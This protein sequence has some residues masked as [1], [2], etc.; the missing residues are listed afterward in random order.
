MGTW[1]LI[2]GLLIAGMLL[3]ALAAADAK[4]HIMYVAAESVSDPGLLEQIASFVGAEERSF[5]LA[6]GEPEP[7]LQADA[8][9]QPLNG[10][11][12]NDLSL[13]ASIR[14][15]DVLILRGGSFMEWYDRISPPGPR[16]FLAAE[17]ADFYR[18][19]KGIVAYGGACMFLSGGALVDRRLKKNPERNP[20]DTHPWIPRIAVGIA[21]PCLFDSSQW[22][23][24]SPL[25]LLQAMV[26]T[27]V[28]RGVFFEGQVALDHDR[29][30]QHE[31]VRGPGSV[32]LFDLRRARTGPTGIR[33]GRLSRLTAGDHWVDG[34]KLPRA[35]TDKRLTAKPTK[36]EASAGHPWGKETG[37]SASQLIDWLPAAH[38]KPATR[39]ATASHWTLAWDESSRRDSGSDEPRTWIH[40]PFD[41][42]WPK[43]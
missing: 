19:R 38:S 15:A 20:Q 39:K 8:Y 24:G 11:A 22:E 23:A 36:E 17:L 42:A 18:A 29:V 3:P 6:F 2:P 43:R 27:Q 16:T 5:T 37:P 35:G 26:E 9:L 10:A 31:V 12:P 40:L 14:Q 33:E 21:P 13:C 1:S 28:D 7:G 30:Q 25:R 32:L 41:C 34:E 4:N